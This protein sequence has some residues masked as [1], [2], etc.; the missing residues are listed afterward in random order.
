[1]RDVGQ[2][3]M[4]SGGQ[5]MPHQKKGLSWLVALRKLNLNG[6]LADEMGTQNKQTQS[7]LSTTIHFLY[8][9]LLKK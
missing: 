1:M 7:F 8:D 4:L 5:L 9:C 6:L 2:P 3:K